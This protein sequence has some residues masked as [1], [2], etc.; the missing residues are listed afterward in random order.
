MSVT[1]SIESVTY[2][3]TCEYDYWLKVMKI[4]LYALATNETWNWLTSNH[5]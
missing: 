4:E 5:M 1:N 2:K 3:E